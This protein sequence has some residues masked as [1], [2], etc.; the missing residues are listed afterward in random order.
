MVNKLSFAQ[1]VFLLSVFWVET[2]RVTHSPEPSLQ[3][4]MEYLSDNALIK[5]K[6]GMWQCVNAVA[7][8]VFER[9]FTNKKSC[10]IFLNMEISLKVVKITHLK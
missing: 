7:D 3:P 10:F 6:Y 1:C 4:I 2:F 8:R 9:Y 5:D